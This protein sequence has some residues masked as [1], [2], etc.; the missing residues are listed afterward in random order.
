MRIRRKPLVSH[1]VASF[2]PFV[3]P[4]PRRNVRVLH[5]PRPANAEQTMT[6]SW[7]LTEPNTRTGPWGC[8]GVPLQVWPGSNHFYR[9]WCHRNIQSVNLFFQSTLIHIWSHWVLDGWSVTR[10][11]WFKTFFMFVVFSLKLSLIH[12]SV[13]SFVWKYTNRLWLLSQKIGPDFCFCSGFVSHNCQIFLLTDRNS[14]FY[15]WYKLKA[16][17]EPLKNLMAVLQILVM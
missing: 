11:S 12:I 10:L 2:R 7:T 3:Y 8:D 14:I 1:I 4:T 9:S 13:D 6:I 15:I 17:P 16:K 5:G